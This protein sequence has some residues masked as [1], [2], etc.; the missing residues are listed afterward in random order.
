MT[1]ADD[2]FA[3]LSPSLS[4]W[5]RFRGAIAGISGAAGTVFLVTLWATEPHLP[6]R[7]Q[8]LFGLLTLICL[9]WTAYGGWAVFRRPLFALDAV[10][11]GWLAVGASVA[12]T[13][14]LVVVTQRL[15]AAMTGAGCL[16]AAVL[17]L[18]EAVSR[19]RA[20]LRRKTELE[21]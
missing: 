9:G 21:S 13:V 3:R 6:A 14:V 11:A 2:Q 10:V 15:A 18:K 12:V 17:L 8:L 1:S 16:L 19:R 7:T 5:G 4:P 20:L